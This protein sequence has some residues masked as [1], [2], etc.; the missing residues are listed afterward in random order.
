MTAPL[1]F[2]ELGGVYPRKDRIISI[3]FLRGLVMIIMALDHVRDFFHQTALTADPLDLATTTPALFFTRWITHFCAPIFVFLSGVSA[4]ISGRGVNDGRH[5]GF[6]IKRGLW[7]V[8]LDLVLI[9]L[10]TSFNPGYNFIFL[11]V[12]WAIG[13]SMILTGLLL[14]L[15]RRLILPLGLLLFFGHNLSALINLPPDGVGGI[16]T[17]IFFGPPFVLPAGKDHAILFAYAILPWTGVMLLGYYFGQFV[18]NRRVV[19]VTGLALIVLFILLRLINLY[20]D[21][22]PFT[23][24]DNFLY[25]LMSFVNTTKYPPSLQFLCM[26]LGP[27]LLILAL[28]GRSNPGWIRFVSVYGKV[29]FFYFVAH[30]LLAHTLQVIAFYASGYSPA[31]IVNPGIPFLFHPVSFGFGLGMTYLVWI[32]V[33]LA[34]YFPCKWFYRYKRS[35]HQWWLRYL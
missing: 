21:P 8:I 13:W 27:G 20:G 33:V 32:T 9:T 7:L 34:L 19:L 24:Q 26:T 15:S 23:P 3:D 6:L 25:S 11:T 14:K 31:D 1:S 12:F 17:R 29:P 4:R 2:E 30:L 18:T 22:R 35:H 5:G 28:I 10:L 16:L